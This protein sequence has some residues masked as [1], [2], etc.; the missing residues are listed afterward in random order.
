VAH[1]DGLGPIEA[2]EEAVTV[3][4]RDVGRPVLTVA[5]RQ[6]VAAQLV[7]HELGPVADPEDGDVAAPDG[8][9][10]LRRG[11]VVHGVRAA[12]QDDP[13]R[14]AAFDLRPRGVVRQELRVDIEL[15]DA[16]RDQLS[17]LAAE[18]EDDDGV[19]VGRAVIRSSLGRGR[20]ERGLEVC[21][22]LGVVRGQHA[23]AG[24]GSFAVNG[25]AALRRRCRRSRAGAPTCLALAVLRHRRPRPPLAIPPGTVYRPG[26]LPRAG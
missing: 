14:P 6:D 19:G 11:R 15:P 23:V 18:V 9:I 8:R 16:A 21:L 24:V 10:R 2:G 20:L 4:D 5:R 7:G 1:P 12:G 26:L 22:D 25:L 17:E 3:A 13:L